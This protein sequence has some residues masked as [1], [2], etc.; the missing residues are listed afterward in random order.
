MENIDHWC[1]WYGPVKAYSPCAWLII[2]TFLLWDAGLTTEAPSAAKNRVAQ[3]VHNC[4]FC[5]IHTFC[6]VADETSNSTEFLGMGHTVSFIFVY[7]LY[8]TA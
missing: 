5:R 3:T 1:F 8:S 2:V 7:A 4:P 6:H